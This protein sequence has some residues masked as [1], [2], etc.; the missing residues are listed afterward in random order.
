MM[1]P[2]TADVDCERYVTLIQEAIDGDLDAAAR[3]ELDAHTAGCEACRTLL[4]DLQEIARAS[5]ELPLHTPRPQVWTHIRSRLEQEQAARPRPFWTGT[6]VVLAMAASLVV[7][8]GA[9]LWVL[10]APA[11]GTQAAVTQSGKDLVK[12]VDEHLRIADSHYEQAIAGL[13][14]VVQTEQA[15]LD[16]AVAETLRNNL[17]VIDK[18]IR[19]SREAIKAQPHSEL[20]QTSLFEALRQKVALLE[21]TIALINVMRKG[22]QAGAARI[23]KGLTKS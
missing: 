1:E 19:E 21:D 20:A 6:R 11:T 9:S 13:E 16:P 5:G 23:V 3:A 8:I 22:D 10:R 7:G 2:R 17:G 15:S 14:Q 12:D 18:A 4:A